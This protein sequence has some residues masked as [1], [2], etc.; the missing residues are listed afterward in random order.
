MKKFFSILMVAMLATAMVSC[1][2][3]NDSDDSQMNIADNTI[4]YDGQTYTID[5]VWVDY[6]HS[7]LTLIS[8]ATGETMDNGDPLVYVDGIHITPNAWNRD[9]DLTDNSQWPDEVSVY[10]IFN[11]V[12][13]IN[14]VGWVNGDRDMSGD[15][16]GVGY[17]HESI[18]TSGTYRVSGNNDGTPITITVNGKLK[19][20]K[21]L[22][23]KIVTGNYN[24]K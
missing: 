8:A 19:N 12:L 10:L 20:G 14:Y 9:F 2:K 13:G 11:G 23:M 21:T 6:Y 15:L 3:D 5:N 18:F 24:T 4:V 17:E 22:Q 7:E 16:D 1:E